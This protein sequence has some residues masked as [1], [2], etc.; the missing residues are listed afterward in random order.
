MR[1][2]GRVRSVAFIAATT[3]VTAAALLG[4]PGIAFATSP[5]IVISQV[6]GGGGNTGAPYTN[7][8]IELY[9]RGPSSVSVSGWSVQ[10]ASAAGSTWSVTP[11]SGSIAPGTYYL[12]QEAAGAGSGVPLPTPDATGTI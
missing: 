3:V 4:H 9:N 7:D 12:I 6:Y 1:P 5:D 11:L 8:Y 2:T 10:Y